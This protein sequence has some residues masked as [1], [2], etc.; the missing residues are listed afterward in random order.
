MN[1]P[2]TASIVILAAVV[3]Y[4]IVGLTL[5]AQDRYSVMSPNGIAF[6]EFKGYDLWAVISP[7]QP[8][9]GVKAIL[10]NG[11]M[12]KTYSDGFPTNGAPVPDGAMMAKVEW[13][14]KANPLSPGS[15]MVP[16]ALTTIGFMV[17]DAKRF[18]ETDGWGYAQ[19]DYNTAS[20][21]FKARGNGPGFAKAACHQCHTKAKERDFVFTGYAP[22]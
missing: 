4:L 15:A 10:G 8:N 20:G 22:R 7:S 14:M 11:V 2:Y 1:R 17:K 16:D 18:P 6:A 3:F 12:M 9:D 13:T 19:F 21:T 5:A